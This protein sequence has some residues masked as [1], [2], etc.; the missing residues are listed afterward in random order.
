MLTN[1][2]IEQFKVNHSA[3]WKTFFRIYSIKQRVLKSYLFWIAVFVN[4]VLSFAIF[5][6]ADSFEALTKLLDLTLSVTP[7][8]LG[9]SLGAYA[10]LTGIFTRD[11]LKRIAEGKTTKINLFQTTSATFGASLLVMSIALILSFFTRQIILVGTFVNIIDS[12]IMIDIIN[13]TAAF[14]INLFAYYSI[15]LLISNVKN[16]F[17]LN[18]FISSMTIIDM[19]KEE[20]DKNPPSEK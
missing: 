19:V 13:A 3:S 14:I 6:A 7:S 18:Q 11:V 9:F 10:L 4:L 2:E 17:G 8:L 12:S 20:N 16:M 15:L 1:E 5:V